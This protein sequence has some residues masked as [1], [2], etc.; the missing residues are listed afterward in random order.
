MNIKI[1]LKDD[2][3]QLIN[4]L[5]EE[6][7]GISFP[8]YKK[9]ML[10]SKLRPRIIEL[11]YKS[12]ME[13]YFY[14]QFSM[15]YEKRIVAQILTNNETFFFRENYQIEAFINH[16][17]EDIKKIIDRN[18]IK[19]LIAGCSGGEEAYSLNIMLLENKY[20]LPQIEWEIFAIDIDMECLIKAKKA[21]YTLNSLRG[22]DDNN[23]SK[24]FIKNEQNYRLKLIY[25]NNIFFEYGN[26]VDVSSYQKNSPYDVIFC[27][28]VLIYFSEQSLF[29][30]I[31]NF[32]R[33]LKKGGLLFLGHSES[34]I[35]LSDFFEPIRY[36][37]CI[38]YKKAKE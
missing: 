32:A 28:N 22:I 2:E 31:K 13:Y 20:K 6:N 16:A 25:K 14:L 4:E 12:F 11:G 29:K 33:V 15:S 5:L 17:V 21:E 27:R 26:I 19:F 30:A 34:I 1:T 3:F 10:E 7:F 38:V 35:G 24:Y 9:Y 18:K 37:D 36:G 23:I 8:E